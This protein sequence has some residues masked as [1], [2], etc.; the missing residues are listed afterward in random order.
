MTNSILNTMTTTEI[1]TAINNDSYI[2]EERKVNTFL[3]WYSEAELL[4]CDMCG[5][6]TARET[7]SVFTDTLVVCK[8]CSAKEKEEKVYLFVATTTTSYGLTQDTVHSDLEKAADAVRFRL[9]LDSCDITMTL[10]AMYSDVDNPHDYVGMFAV[11]D[12]VVK[13]FN[14]QTATI[15]RIVL[16]AQY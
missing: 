6:L 7:S 15:K 8:G 14:G 4:T 3:E 11:G 1:L 13:E 5:C 12:E 16:D 2:P 10:T 9:Q